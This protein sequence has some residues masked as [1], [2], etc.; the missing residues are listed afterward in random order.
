MTRTTLAA[1]FKRFTRRPPPPAPTEPN[2]LAFL[3]LTHYRWCPTCQVALP[4]TAY[5]EPGGHRA[6]QS[7]MPHTNYMHVP[8][9]PPVPCHECRV[10]VVEGALERA[11]E[12]LRAN[13]QPPISEP[14]SVEDFNWTNPD[15]APPDGYA[16][17]SFLP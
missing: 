6:N 8:G 11:N 17:N 9:A 2:A 14:A 16:R 4:K 13:G 3:E 7:G 12:Y 1:W 10:K 5:G 15:I